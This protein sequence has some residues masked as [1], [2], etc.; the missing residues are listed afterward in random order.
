MKWHSP[1][2]ACRPVHRQYFCPTDQLNLH[3][4]LLSHSN[5]HVHTFTSARIRNWLHS[6]LSSIHPSIHPQCIHPSTVYAYIIHLPITIHEWIHA[7]IQ[8]A[9]IQRSAVSIL[10]FT[11]HTLIHHPRIQTYIH[12][13]I[14]HPD[15]IHIHSRGGISWGEGCASLI[16]LT[17]HSEVWN[18]YVK[19]NPS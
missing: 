5:S 15:V 2:H 19:G 4:H 8:N 7:S 1:P 13:Y 12:T 3:S 11:S 18:Q 16:V 6:H 17:P 9:S 14:H 10:P